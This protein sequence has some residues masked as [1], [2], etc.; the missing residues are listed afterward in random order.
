MRIVNAR[1]YK[2]L[3]Q[4]SHKQTW[5]TISGV[6]IMGVTGYLLSFITINFGQDLKSLSFI[7]YNRNS[8]QIVRYEEHVLMY[9][10]CK[11]CSWITIPQIRTGTDKL[12]KP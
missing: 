9:Q 7:T 10:L 8:S 12:K 3:K 1:H 11:E 6:R 2:Y 4:E 5:Y